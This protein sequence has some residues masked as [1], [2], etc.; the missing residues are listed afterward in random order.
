MRG[1]ALDRLN[2]RPART[3]LTAS[4]PRHLTISPP[5]H[6][7]TSPLRHPRL[8]RSR[9]LM[10]ME[11]CRRYAI[12]CT[13][14]RHA[15]PYHATPSHTEPCCGV[16][17]VVGRWA[18]GVLRYCVVDS[19]PTRRASARPCLLT[20]G[21]H[22]T[23]PPSHHLTTSPNYSESVGGAPTKSQRKSKSRQR[24]AKCINRYVCV[25]KG[26]HPPKPHYHKI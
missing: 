10:T 21:C 5:R 20:R 19:K 7:A 12:L 26:H 18:F 15:T 11:R 14:P 9:L 2:V 17:G 6:L 16:R 25:T 3:S 13:M 4:P 8:L 23:T 22:F 24:S 1:P